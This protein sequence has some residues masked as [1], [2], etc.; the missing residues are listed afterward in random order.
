MMRKWKKESLPLAIQLYPHY[1]ITGFIPFRC[2]KLFHYVT[3]WQAADVE[4]V[5]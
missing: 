1:I 4:E 2:G 5:K 3:L